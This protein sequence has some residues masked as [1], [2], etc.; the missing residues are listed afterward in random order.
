MKLT[1]SDKRDLDE[2]CERSGVSTFWVLDTQRRARLVHWLIHRTDAPITL[3][4]IQFPENLVR[5][6]NSPGF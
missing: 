6:V 2:L 3:T 5:W 4:P 1:P